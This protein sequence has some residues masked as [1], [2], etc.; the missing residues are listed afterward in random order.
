MRRRRSSRRVA[1]S[2]A[3]GAPPRP[4]LQPQLPPLCPPVPAAA[5]TARRRPWPRV[6]LPPW[7][8]PLGRQSPG[9]RPRPRA[10]G[11]RS[12]GRTSR[13][14]AS[15]D[16]GAWSRPSPG[17]GGR[18]PAPEGPLARAASERRASAPAPAWRSASSPGCRPAAPLWQPRRCQQPPRAAPGR[19]G[20]LTWLGA[21][22]TRRGSACCPI[23]RSHAPA[24]AHP[25]WRPHRLGAHE[26]SSAEGGYL[27]EGQRSAGIPAP[28]RSER[29]RNPQ[30]RTEAS[31][32]SSRAA[33]GRP[34]GHCT[35][36]SRTRR[37]RPADSGLVASGQAR[38]RARPARLCCRQ[39]SA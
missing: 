37:P 28:R 12:P 4:A 34:P 11:S 33:A 19:A 32:P 10:A 24:T 38:R 13:C 6:P 27:A 22:A 21:D 31:C 20:P 39:C 9:R 2:A 26:R 18:P 30:W 29:P 16:P 8:P 3:M 15:L 23:R 25:T 7:R 14:P 5:P 36:V 1:Q 17:P 35:L